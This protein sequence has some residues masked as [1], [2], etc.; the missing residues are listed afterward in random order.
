M[1]VTGKISKQQN[2][3]LIPIVAHLTIYHI[4]RSLKIPKGPL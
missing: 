3:L 4:S 2:N 1:V